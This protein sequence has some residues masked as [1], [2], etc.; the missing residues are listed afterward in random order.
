[1]WVKWVTWFRQSGSLCVC[2]AVVRCW[3]LAVRSAVHVGCC[4]SVWRRQWTRCIVGHD[5]W[6]KSWYRLWPGW[7][8][9]CSV[10]W[11]RRKK[12]STNCATWSSTHQVCQF[13]CSCWFFSASLRHCF[14]VQRENSHWICW[15]LYST[16]YTFNIP[17][18]N[19][20]GLMINYFGFSSLV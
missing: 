2:G 16:V 18:W 8:W 19:L 1:M 15:K 17:T 5:I 3:L 6:R 13:S 4:W 14:T 10:L 12:G 9:Q 20:L 11:R 7:H